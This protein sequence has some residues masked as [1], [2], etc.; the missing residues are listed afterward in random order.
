MAAVRV[1][2][3]EDEGLLRRTLAQLLDAQPELEVVG[4]AADGNEAVAVAC[5]E[6][7]DVVL[8][9]LALPVMSGIEAT[10]AVKAQLPGTAVVV[11]TQL[12]DDESLF[13]ALKAGAVGYV[14]KDAELEQIVE[15]IR[16]A[17]AG[18]GYLSPA[19]V[20]RVLAEFGRISEQAKR[21]RAIFESLTRREMEVL[22]LIGA[23]LRNRAIGQRLFI[24]ESTV[25]THVGAIL[26][27]LH[28]ND[29]TEAAVVAERH[30]LL[31]DEA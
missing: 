27:K 7:P 11:L 1:L 30:G 16:L 2:I 28:L 5:R 22:E 3:V 23:G 31:R 14:L 18:G 29:R 20:P 26:S 8:M 15:A 21:R 6:Q 10:R 9:D 12:N 4:S 17:H 24:S 25:K 19:V 13:A